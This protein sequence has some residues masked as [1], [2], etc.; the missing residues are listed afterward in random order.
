[1]PRD[2]S[3]S[4]QEVT[5]A[6]LRHRALQVRRLMGGMISKADYDRFR[7]YADEMETRAAKL[8]AEGQAL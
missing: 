1:M 6:D 7:A 8:E 5:A 2:G 4:E 3:I